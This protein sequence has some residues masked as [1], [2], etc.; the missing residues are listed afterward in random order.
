MSMRSSLLAALMLIVTAAGAA[1]QTSTP[2]PPP[3]GALEPQST[4]PLPGAT[5]QTPGAPLAPAPVTPPANVVSPPPPGRIFAAEQGLIFNAIRPD[6]IA[7]FETVI[8]KL[9]QALA[10]SK[11]PVRNQQGWGWKI[12]KAAEPGPNG[13]VLYV[14]VMDPAV[15]GADYGVAKILAEAYPTEILELY[16]M[17][18]GAFATAGQTLLN[19]QPVP[20]P[21]TKGPGNQGTKAPNA[22]SSPV[23]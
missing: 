11:D 12:F 2:Q 7:D 9:R 17:Y 1:G 6:K 10:T 15:K 19:L 14:F 4:S 5:P 8:A 16:R 20:E 22:P 13:S 23:P 3:A 18:S 21:G